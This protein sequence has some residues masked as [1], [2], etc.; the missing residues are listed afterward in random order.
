MSQPSGQATQAAV[1]KKNLLGQAVQLVLSAPQ[2][3]QLV[4]EH[5]VHFPSAFGPNPAAQPPAW[6][7]S[8]SRLHLLQVVS[9]QATQDALPTVAGPNLPVHSS[10]V[11]RLEHLPQLAKH[12][13]HF[14]GV[15]VS[16]AKESEHLEQSVA[17]VQVSQPSTQAAQAPALFQNFEAQVVQMVLLLPQVRQLAAHLT[18]FPEASGPDPTGQPP[19]RQ[20]VELVLHLVQVGSAQAAHAFL[21]AEGPNRPVHLAQVSRAGANALAQSS[22]L[23]TL[24][25]SHLLEVV[26]IL[27]PIGSH[28]VQLTAEE[29]LTQGAVQAVHELVV[30]VTAAV[31]KNLLLQV[32]HWVART[33]EQL[34]QLVTVHGEQLKSD[35]LGGR[36]AG[37]VLFLPKVGL[38]SWQPVKAGSVPGKGVLQLGIGT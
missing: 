16:K 2:A 32:E 4:T 22:Q 7:L 9:E 29:Q 13:V 17:L 33:I 23:R 25:L 10:Q 15:A 27:N 31:K 35:F 20:T 30:A 5:A 36:S 11:V 8:G 37:L 19:A 21:S 24:H 3:L 1:L 26:L 14:L 6:H 34:V 12:L 28:E 18:H 38:H